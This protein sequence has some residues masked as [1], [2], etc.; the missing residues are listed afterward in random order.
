MKN[1]HIDPESPSRLGFPSSSSVPQSSSEGTLPRSGS[2][3]PWF[4]GQDSPTTGSGG[5]SSSNTFSTFPTHA[6]Q[7]ITTSEEEYDLNEPPL[8]EELGIRFEDILA[9]TQA[10]MV[11]T[12]VMICF[13]TKTSQRPFHYYS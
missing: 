1:I 13:F 9:K 8:L 3:D 7:S 4:S 6:S 10:V 11:P 12:K 2:E 5:Q